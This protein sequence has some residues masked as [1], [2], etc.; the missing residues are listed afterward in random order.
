MIS[1]NRLLADG[2]KQPEG[3]WAPEKWKA[4]SV[5]SWQK[6]DF[7]DLRESSH[8]LIHLEH[9]RM[10]ASTPTKFEGKKMLKDLNVKGQDGYKRQ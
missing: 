2:P 10:W 3:V 6:R 1:F 5:E 9:K 7:R 4:E 8:I